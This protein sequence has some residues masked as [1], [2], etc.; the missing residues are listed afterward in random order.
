M[1]SNRHTVSIRNDV[2]AKLLEYG[3][4]GDSF[5][6]LIMRILNQLEGEEKKVE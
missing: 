5:S 3:K 6:S 1:M 2:Y 4:F